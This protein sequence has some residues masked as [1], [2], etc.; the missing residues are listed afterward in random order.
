MHVAGMKRRGRLRCPSS[1]DA[2][3]RRAWEWVARSPGSTTRRVSDGRCSASSTC[4]VRRAPSTSSGWAPSAT[5]S[6]TGSSRARPPAV[7]NP[8]LALHPVALPAARGG[9]GPGPPTPT[10]ASGDSR[11]TWFV[12]SRSGGESE[13]VI[14]I[15][16]QGEGAAA[17]VLR[18]LGRPRALR[19]PAVPGSIGRYHASLDAYY[20]SGGRRR[21]EGDE[22]ELIDAGRRNW[23][24]GLPPAPADLLERTT[25][26]LDAP[27]GRVPARAVRHE[28][29]RLDAR[30]GAPAPGGPARTAAR[31]GSTRGSAR[32][33][34]E[35]RG[36]VDE[37]ERFSLLMYGAVLVYNAGDGGARR[38]PRPSAADPRRR[39]P[40]LPTR[41]GRDQRI[42]P[43]L[44]ELRAW[45]RGEL[46]RLVSAM[47][48]GRIGRTRDFAERWMAAVIA[49]PR[50]PFD[51]P[52]IRD[53]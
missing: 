19:D 15:E 25:F 47:L 52:A 17:A 32:L 48:H 49:H 14:G 27:R 44:G 42:E 39:V 31:R 13:G 24:A 46:W 33:R 18:V 51:D 7:A 45:D 2:A 38:E 6:P 50:E 4:S 5:R 8:V 43:R 11:P 3:G 29:R 36:V 12:P 35:L 37:G 23:H 20:R 10:V 26:Q 9:E 53:R 41:N 40:G 28:G 21:S 1:A 16:R 34:P 22:S 30:V